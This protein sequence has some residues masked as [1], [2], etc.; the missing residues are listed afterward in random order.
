MCQ[1]PIALGSTQAIQR[2]FRFSHGPFL[3]NAYAMKEIANRA[4]LEDAIQ[5]NPRLKRI[6][7]AVLAENS[8]D[9]AHDISHLLRVALYTLRLAPDTPFEEAVASALLHDFVNVPKNHPDRAKASQLSADKGAT[10]L[11]SLGFPPEAITRVSEAIRQHSFS[12]GEKPVT[13]LAQALQ[14][15]DRLEALGAIGLMRVISTGAKMGAKYFDGN[16][17]W[18]RRRAHDDTAFSVDHFFTK[19]LRLPETMNTEAGK[20]EAKRRA[21]YLRD[22]LARLGEEIGEAP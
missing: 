17:P 8:D 1:S 14:D 11:S 20:R 13:P 16:D 22:F 4:A 15:A 18:A 21:D 12:R 5:A 10:L 7:E 3:G 9:A 19:L 6:F 2:S